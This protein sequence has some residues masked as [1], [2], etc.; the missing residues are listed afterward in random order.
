MPVTASLPERLISLALRPDGAGPGHRRPHGDRDLVRD[1]AMESRQPN[2]AAQRRGRRDGAA[3][4]FSPDG[5]DLAVGTQQGT[6]L[7]WSL[8]IPNPKEPRL[9]LPG[10]RGI[11]T[12]LVYDRQGGKLASTAVGD[13]LVEVWDLDL[14]RHELSRLGIA[15]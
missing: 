4:S 10:H 3:L 7:I 6:I 8:A 2:Q 5:R 9:G 15:D 12:S 11:I 13:P 14:I 1:T